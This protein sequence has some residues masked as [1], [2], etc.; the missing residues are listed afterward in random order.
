MQ[1]LMPGLVIGVI[2]GLLVLAMFVVPF[3]GARDSNAAVVTAEVKAI[4]VSL[5]GLKGHVDA[6][7]ESG[8]LHEL[9]GLEK[10]WQMLKEGLSIRGLQYGQSSTAFEQ[11]MAELTTEVGHSPEATA[12]ALKSLNS[13]FAGVRADLLAAVVVEPLRLS[14]TLGGLILA[15]LSLVLITSW[16]SDRMSVKQ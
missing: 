16:L 2:S 4:D 6:Q 12:Q 14:F 7:H 11:H 15:W 13:S 5:K 1:R 3:P 10:Q 8:A 9:T